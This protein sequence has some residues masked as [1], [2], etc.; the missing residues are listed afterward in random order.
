MFYDRPVNWIVQQIEWAKSFFNEA[1]GKASNKRLLSTAVV[2][3]FIVPYF[4]VSLASQKL[5]DIPFNWMLTVGGIIGLNI[6]DWAIKG[7]LNKSVESK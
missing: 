4:K 7:Y 1:D 6:A 5:E 3:A 2:V